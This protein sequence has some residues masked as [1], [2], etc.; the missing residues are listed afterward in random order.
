VVLV[1]AALVVVAAGLTGTI[2][3]RAVVGSTNG[4]GVLVAV[5]KGSS[6]DSIGE[7]LAR[8]R[9]I[10][11]P[12]LF[13]VYLHLV[14]DP[15][16]R[17]GEYRMRTD[18]GYRQALSTLARGPLS[19]KLVIPE[20]LTVKEIAQRVGQL[21]GHSAASFLALADSGR[22]RSP[23]QPI[24]VDSLEGLL[25][26]D[27]YE[28]S[29]NESDAGIL[30]TMI[31]EMVKVTTETGLDSAASK[32]GVTPY[33]V[34]T[35]ASLVEREAKLPSDGPR[36]ARVVYNR[37]T[38]GI[39]LQLD[40]TVVYALGD[41]PSPPTLAQIQS[42]DS[43]YNTYLHTGLPP[44]P[45]ANPGQADLMAAEHPSPGQWLYFATVSSDGA[46]GFFDTYSA[47]QAAIANQSA[48]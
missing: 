7:L 45:I 21:P 41:P 48:G 28:I 23:L 25:F 42:T 36:V 16:V 13:K 31:D 29:P 44:T 5:P 30:N 18:E 43:P 3:E 22:L 47:M 38:A 4:Q 15:V 40:S 1:L 19:F 11:H 17:P 24:G 35:V 9:V 12:L 39:R 32:L 46:E 34:L 37:L 2:Y 10:S 14:A 20:G 8:R 6:L 26:P 27:T 33:Q